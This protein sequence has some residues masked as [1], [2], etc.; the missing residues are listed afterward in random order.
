MLATQ[1]PP[2]GADGVYK[3]EAGQQNFNSPITSRLREIWARILHD[4]ASAFSDN[5]VFFEVGGDSISAQHLISAAKKQGILLTMEQIFMHASL[6]EMARVARVA[7]DAAA[8]KTSTRPKTLSGLSSGEQHPMQDKLDAIAMKCG[9]IPGN[10]EDAYSCSPMQESLVAELDV[11]KSAYLRQFVFSMSEH[12]PLDHFRQAWEDTVLAN[13]VL[14]TRVCYVGG[15]HGYVQAVVNEDTKWRTVRGDLTQF[16]EQ[17]AGFPMRPDG[18]LFRYTILEAE[19]DMGNIQRHFVWTA[20]HALCDGVSIVEI[21]DEVAKRFRGEAVPLRQSFRSFI[22]SPAVMPDREQEQHF[23]RRSLSGINPTAYPPVPQAP[24][25]RAEPTSELERP[26]VLGRLPPFGVTKALLLRAAWAILVS[27]YTGTEDVGFGVINSGRGS[28]VHGVSQM[29]GPTINLVPIALRIDPTQSVA[30]F[31]SAVRAQAA[32]MT[33]FEHTGISRIRKYL[34]GRES[35]ALDFQTILVVHPRALSD[36]LAPPLQTLGLEYVDGMGKKEQHSYPLVVSFTLSGDTTVMLKMQHD[37]RVVSTQQAHNLIHQF[38]AVLMQLSNATG[39]ALLESISPFSDHDM[40]QLRQW[41]AFTPPAEE[42]CVH[43]LFQKQVLKQPSAVAVCSLEASLTYSDVDVCSSSLAAHLIELGTAPGDY[44]AV[45]FEKSIWT[46]VAILAVFKAGGVYV[47]IDP[48]H[49]QGR[50]AEVVKTVRIRMAIAS[51]SSAGALEGLS[52]HVITLDDRPPPRPFVSKTPAVLPSSVAYL[53]F[54]S[55]STGKPKGILISHSA[56]CTSIKHHGPAFGAGTHWRTLQFGA[57]TFDMSIGE[58]FTTLSFGGCI[59]VPSE[60][61]RMNNLAG[62]IAALNVNTLLV[63]PT[64]ANLL[65]P[66]EVPTVRTIVLGGEPVTQ[67]LVR[68]WAD[69]VNLI[70]SYGP[71]EC[72]VWSSAN[73]GVSADADPANIGRSIGGTMWIVNPDNHH[74]LSAIGCVGEIAISGAIVGAGYFNDGPATEAAFVS[75]PGWLETFDPISPYKTLYRTGDLA[76][77]NPDGSFHIIGRRDTQVKLRGFRIEL[78]EIENQMMTRSTVKAAFT[79]LPRTGPCAGQIVAVVCPNRSDLAHHGG[80]SGNVVLS[81]EPRP[82]LREELR[83]HLS[84][85]LP[86]YMVPSVYIVLEKMPLLISGKIDRRQLKLWIENMTFDLYKEQTEVPGAS[87]EA[88]VVLGSRADTLRQLWSEV[89]NVPV[90]VIGAKTSFFALGGD[91][92]AAIQI[93]SRA[94]QLGLPVTVREIISAKTLGNLAAL[95]EQSQ[96]DVQGGGNERLPENP[97]WA[98]NGMLQPYES[99]LRARLKH[100]PSVQAVD[101]YPLSPFQRE[102]MK[103]RIANPP[104]FLLSWQ[105]EIISLTPDQISLDRLASAWKYVVQK[106]PI[107]R[108]IFLK[109]PAGHL[110]PLQVVLAHAEPEITVASAPADKME[111][112]FDSTKTPPVDEC[113]LP[114]RAQFTQHGDRYFVHIELDHRILDGWSL[115]LIRTAL[116]EAY[117]KEDAFRPQDE[118][119]SYKAFIA[120]H[121]PDRVEADDRYWASALRGQRPCLLS[122]PVAGVPSFSHE[123][124]DRQQP[125]PPPNATKTIIYLPEIKAQALMAFGVRHGITAASIFDAAWAQT[126]SLHTGSPDVAFEY[127]VSGRH[128]DLPDVFAIV[129]PLINVL[130]YHLRDVST[131]GGAP[132]VAH[133][134]Q[135]MQEQRAHDSL[136]TASNVREVVE[137]QLGVVGPLFNTALNFQR[138]PT[139]VQTDRLRLDD[140]LRKSKDP[141]HFDVL[142]RVLHITDDATFRPSIEFDPLLFDEKQ[143]N[144]VAEDFWRRVQST[145]S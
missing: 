115:G 89:L 1:S 66:H 57:H 126:L 54:T 102:I 120:T 134:A 92:I 20:H 132:Q 99:L 125:P 145:I 18:P 139:A 90:D 72:A 116:V 121:R 42:T 105:M 97:Q 3:N 52:M 78:G 127:V 138:R 32:E 40:A 34:A 55:G 118:P 63:A 7:D 94:R 85:V 111:P 112:T 96:A 140:H 87:E 61:D 59:C 88:E 36:A 106:Y 75:A 22:D 133:L 84:H 39:D 69:H 81:R 24:E 101:A 6:E 117:E 104:I 143:M 123:T 25:F 45:C 58:F 137:R 14:R 131:E 141:W 144:G 142:V 93:V 56:I 15:T 122:L 29:T 19:N 136:H 82:L 67:E 83:R 65:W 129:G 80:G 68:R 53:L 76:R 77:Y 51:S 46:V 12:L 31:L 11:G 43:E 49:P 130:P 35:T 8:N 98:G 28:A 64:V 109:D 38:Q 30:S 21:L 114:H 128:E 108:T 44:V 71:S 4:D 113:F 27:H 13:P 16:L 119:P 9:V 95:V 2:Y 17:D 74:Q 26:L 5:D 70:D 79:A 135:R 50:I 86:A 33:S 73:L 124:T 103:A 23:W 110:P 91:S 37:E 100:Q 60:H 107:L 47:P 62:S 48:A 10:I 41:N